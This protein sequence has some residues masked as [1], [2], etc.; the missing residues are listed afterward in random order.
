MPS[1]LIFALH[2]FTGT[3]A[4]FECARRFFPEDAFR[5]D[6][7]DIPPLALPETLAF[8]RERAERLR[9]GTRAPLS[10]LGYSMGGRLALHLA[11]T[12]P[13]RAGDRLVLVSASPGLA[14]ARERALRREAD[15]ALARKIDAAESAEAFYSEWRKIPLI[16]TQERQPSPWRERL[17]ARRAAADKSVWAAHLR[18]LGTGTLPSLW[19]GLEEIP[20][21]ETLLV[22]GEEDEKFRRLAERMREA[23]PRSRVETVPACGHS[24]HLENPAAFARALLTRVRA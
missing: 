22:V 18:A 8:L 16:A 5:W 12:F 24:P 20:A 19:E 6:A 13:W 11:R 14:D 3:G 1:A 17:R 7:P 2:G 10:L 23:I 9:A 4:D 15:E 21:P